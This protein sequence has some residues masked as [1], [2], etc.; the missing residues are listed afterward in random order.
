MVGGTRG[1]ERGVTMLEPAEAS[2]LLERVL[3]EADDR[4]ARDAA[5][6]LLS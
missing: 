6:L 3:G 5:D 4:R 1:S 2:S